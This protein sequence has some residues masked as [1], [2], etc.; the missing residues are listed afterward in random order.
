M[1]VVFRDETIPK[2]ANFFVLCLQRWF[3]SVLPGVGS[4]G[5]VGPKSARC[6]W[7]SNDRRRFWRMHGHTGA[8]CHI[9][10]AAIIIY[11]YIPVACNYYRYCYY[12]YYILVIFRWIRLPSTRSSVSLVRSTKETQN[13]IRS[14][15][16]AGRKSSNYSPCV[17]ILIAV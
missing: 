2:A 11:N 8:Y 10:A 7:V 9:H 17:L 5:R 13:F 4:V 12:Y 1:F 15:H 16:R 3:W 14:F 6:P